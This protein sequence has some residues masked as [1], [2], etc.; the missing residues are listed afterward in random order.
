MG[1]VFPLRPTAGV[2]VLATLGS[3]LPAITRHAPREPWWRTDFSQA[4]STGRVPKMFPARNHL[5]KPVCRSG[6][7]N[8]NV[9][10]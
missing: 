2:A 10:V 1:P 6:G 5:W 3:G 4:G 7:A 8:W 9:A